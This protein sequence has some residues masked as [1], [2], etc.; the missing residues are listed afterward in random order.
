MLV[1]MHDLISFSLKSLMEKLQLREVKPV[2][3]GYT[4]AK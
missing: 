1:A 4:A 2:P 3:Q